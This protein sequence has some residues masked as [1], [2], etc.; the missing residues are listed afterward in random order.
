MVE[1]SVPYQYGTEVPGLK[2][3]YST[4]SYMGQKYSRWAADV[5]DW[6]G[7][8]WDGG[9]W[10]LSCWSARFLCRGF[11]VADCVGFVVGFGVGWS[12]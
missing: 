7:C 1:I 9:C 5:V 8:G 10:A 6:D 2:E 12:G 3:K 11:L 4:N